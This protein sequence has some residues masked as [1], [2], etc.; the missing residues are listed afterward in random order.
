MFG[1]NYQVD[2]PAGKSGDWEVRKFEV[3][4]ED[5]ARQRIRASFRDGRFVPAGIYTG[6]Y[7]GKQTVM[8]DTPDEIRDHRQAIRRATGHCLVNGLGIGMVA[9]AMLRKPEVTKVTV[10]EL[11]ADVIALVAP[12]WKAKYGDRIEII[13]SDAMAYQ[14]PKGVRYGCV[15]HDIWDDI[16]ADNLEDMKKLHRKYGRRCEWQGSWCRAECEVQEN[17]WRR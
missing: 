3:T 10:I 2:V 6:I 1:E 5:E 4:P 17:R 12:H 13:Q 14:P 7:R 16:C 9:A 15:W 11:S 8:S